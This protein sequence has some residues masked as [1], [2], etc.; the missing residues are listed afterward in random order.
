M[1]F[2]V[3]YSASSSKLNWLVPL[4]ILLWCDASQFYGFPSSKITY[5][6]IYLQTDSLLYPHT[7]PILLH[8]HY[9]ISY[10]FVLG[11]SCPLSKWSIVKNDLWPTEHWQTPMIRNWYTQTERETRV[12]QNTS[13]HTITISKTTGLVTKHKWMR[14]LVQVIALSLCPLVQLEKYHP[15][16]LNKSLT[17]SPFVTPAESDLFW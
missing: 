3:W 10:L 1:C 4:L 5:T 6:G 13:F 16:L 17:G 9:I 11:S 12:G 8:H 2:S 7:L 14:S 15:P